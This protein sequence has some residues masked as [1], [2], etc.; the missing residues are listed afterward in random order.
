MFEHDLRE[1]KELTQYTGLK[2]GVIL[3]PIFFLFAYFGKEDL[4]LAVVIVLAA[5]IVAIRIRW[6]LR[7]RVWFWAI[8]AVVLVLHI[9]LVFMVRWPQGSLPTLFYTLPFALIDFL[10]VSGLLRLAEQFF[11]KRPSAGTTKRQNC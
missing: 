2:I 11:S 1:S 4:G 10:I 5:M 8:L 7:K 6:N 9:P 3:L